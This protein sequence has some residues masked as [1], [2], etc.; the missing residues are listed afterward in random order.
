MTGVGPTPPER[1]HRAVELG[2]QKGLRYVYEGNI[3]GGHGSDTMCP[4]CGTLL[5]ARA[6][7]SSLVHGLREGACGKC[8]LA[9]AGVWK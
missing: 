5:V 6:G 8:G 9:I 7:F 2:R 3:P 4:Q 1:L